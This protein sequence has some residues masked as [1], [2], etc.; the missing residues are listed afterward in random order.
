M[1]PAEAPPSLVIVVDE[2]ATLVQE[3]PD[4][5][6]GMVDMAQRGR[7]LGIHLVLATQ[8]PTGA[9]NDNILANTNLRIALRVLDSA[10]SSAVIGAKDAA[11]IPVPLRGRAY[12]R[13]GPGA[14][15]PFQCAWSGAP[16]SPTRS[17]EIEQ[18]QVAVVRPFPF[19]AADADQVRAGPRGRP[20]GGRL[21]TQLEALVEVAAT[22]ARS[23]G[24]APARPP[25]VEPLSEQVGLASLLRGAPERGEAHQRDPGRWVTIGLAD[26]PDQ[27]R[28]ALVDV[29]LEADG[30]LLVFGSGGSGKTTLL[31]TVAA[32]LAGQGGPD[33][34]RIWVLDFSGRSLTH[35]EELPHVAAVATGDDLERVTRML[36]VLDRNSNDAVTYWPRLAASRFR[37]CGRGEGAT[38][39]REWCCSSMAT[40]AFMPPS[41]RARFIPGCCNWSISSP[42][43]ARSESTP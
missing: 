30:G 25:W 43:A 20:A 27:Q 18:S 34:V 11:A 35:L 41:R 2:F 39:C 6:A 8:R 40:P 13:T 32:D 12:A 23:L 16:Y 24:L 22:T 36:T 31:R 9:V 3:I 28:Q 21:P 5:V 10:D 1:A 17:K 14:L 7:S 15:M 29:D 37:P 4:F 33:E 26:L 42:R 38:A 19:G